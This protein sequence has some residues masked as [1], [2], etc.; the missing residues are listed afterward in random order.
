V[1]VAKA[2]G[3]VA[4]ARVAAAAVLVLALGCG[5]GE[6]APAPVDPPPAKSEAAPPTW[7]RGAHARREVVEA[8]REDAGRER[9]PGDGGGE[10]WLKSREPVTAS[11]HGRWTIVY[12]AGPHGVAVGGRILL[13][14][15]PF[16]HWSTPQT[17]N[18]RVPGFTTV[19]SLA[20][21]VTLTA[22]TLDQQLLGIEVGGRALEE[23]ERI[24]I[25][26]G[27]GVSGARAD[28]FAERESR[29]FVGVDADGDGVRAWTARSPA[30]TVRPGEPRRLLVHLP[31]VARPGE[32]VFATVAVLDADANAGVKFAGEIVFGEHADSVELPPS[33]ALEES[34]R[35]VARVPL[36]VHAEGIVRLEARGPDELV[37]VSNPMRVS[38]EA[39]RI[40]F[41]DLHGHSNLSDGTGTPEDYFAYAR[42]VA[43]LDFTSLTDHDHWGIPFLDE[44][45]DLRARIRRAAEAAHA[46]GHFVTLHGYEW[47]SWIYGHR[48]VLWFDDGEHAWPSSLAPEFES[49][50]QLWD[51]LRGQPAMTLA[52]H[53]AG[54]PIATDWTIRPD[55]ELEPLTEIVSVHGSSEAPDTPGPIYS[56]VRG[57]FVRSALR[58]GYRL[59]FVGSGDSHDGHPGLAH[60]ARGSGGLAAVFTEDL[61]REALRTA[62]SDRL[63][64]ATNGPRILLEVRLAGRLMGRTIPAAELGEEATLVVDAVGTGEIERVDVVRSGAVVA[65]ADA[66]GKADLLLGYPVRGLRA[67]EY[68]YVRV[69]QRDG[70]AAWSSPFFVE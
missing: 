12:E 24:R 13:Q 59:G 10:A 55:P 41:G 65:S 60:L 3:T 1:S 63:A 47:T 7:E 22:E 5:G 70:G 58:R 44:R 40:R 8:L 20:E 69:V 21:G 43:A 48:H 57:N 14:I 31:G 17:S 35:G 4:G 52:H 18:P 19:E 39:P 68:L 11:G 33:V 42:D 6:E 61:T 64:Y 25:V 30:V 28:R 36:R 62:L 26:Y 23:G 53:S 15:S 45:A 66:E 56:P 16:W 27:A 34:Q 46:P 32:T 29:F 9:H 49:P 54:G 2:R 51:A 50:E 67:G 37:A 38:T